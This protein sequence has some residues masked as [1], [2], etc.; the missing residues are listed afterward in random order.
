MPVRTTLSGAVERDA[1][2]GSALPSEE[3]GG[4]EQ[5]VRAGSAPQRERSGA[6]RAWWEGVRAHL[7]AF[8]AQKRDLLAGR[9]S[10]LRPPARP[11]A[12]RGQCH[13][14]GRERRAM[15]LG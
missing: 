13:D 8:A 6:K 15:R 9:S 4:L 7:E 10:W 12:S 5:R 14:C 3:G 1:V 2:M 11:A